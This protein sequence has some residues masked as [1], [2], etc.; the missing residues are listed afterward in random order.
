[1]ATALACD[2]VNVKQR[3]FLKLGYKMDFLLINYCNGMKD[4]CMCFKYPQRF[5]ILLCQA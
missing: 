2:W 4:F 1:M 3:H 5:K